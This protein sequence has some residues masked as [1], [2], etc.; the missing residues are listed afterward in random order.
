LEEWQLPLYLERVKVK[1][2]DKSKILGKV[3]GIEELLEHIF[4]NCRSLIGK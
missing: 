1:Y 2:Y 3:I 4:F